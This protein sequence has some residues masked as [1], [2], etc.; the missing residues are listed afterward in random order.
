MNV[1][2]T[3]APTLTI[4]DP[5]AVCAPATVDLTAA[6]ITAGSPAGLTYTY[7][8]DAA[9]TVAVPTPTAVGNGTYYIVGTAAGGCKSAPTQVNVTVT[10]APTLTITDPAAVCAPATVDLTAAA[11]TAGT[12]AGLTYTYFTNAAGTTPVPTPTAVGNGTYYIVG[13]TAAGCKSVPTQVNVT[14]TPA[15]SG[16]YNH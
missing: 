3:T 15:R 1:T 8:S 5:A 11:V 7:F 10:T 9:G 6:G 13:T 12:P 16:S 2:V 4:T 14:V